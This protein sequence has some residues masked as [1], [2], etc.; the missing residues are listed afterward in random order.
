MPFFGQ[1]P[2]DPFELAAM[3]ELSSSFQDINISSDQRLTDVAEV[4]V[5]NVHR[6]YS[7]ATFVPHV[8][9]HAGVQGSLEAIGKYRVYGSPEI[10]PASSEQAQLLIDKMDGLYLEW[11]QRHASGSGDL[12]R[13]T[14]GLASLNSRIHA[15]DVVVTSAVEGLL[16]SVVL[17]TWTAFEVLAGDLWEAA[18]NIHP[19]ELAELK[20]TTRGW[21]R[22]SNQTEGSDGQA[23]NKEKAGEI[24]IKT[25]YT[26]QYG[27]DLSNRMGTV[28]RGRL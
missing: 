27:Y 8:A 24:R 28:L 1:P 10:D 15:A 25:A 9:F 4:F 26:Q 11:N 6:A 14:L 17:T 2:D 3:A 23:A 7:L 22:V 13:W 18:L 19:A 5:S 16:Q 21:G 12:E 20:G